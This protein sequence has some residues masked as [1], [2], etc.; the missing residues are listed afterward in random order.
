[1]PI[2]LSNLSAE[3]IAAAT[4]AVEAARRARQERERREVEE[5]RKHQ[6]EERARQ[7]A[8]MRREAE[9]RKEAVAWKAEAEWRDRM[10]REKAAREAAAAET[11]ATV[12][13]G[14]SGLKLTIP[15]PA[16]I[17]RTASGSSTQSKGK[18]KAAEEEP[19]TSQCV[20]FIPFSFLADFLWRSRFL[21]CDSCTIIGIPCSTE[22]RKNGMRR[23]LCDRCRQLKKACHWDLVGVTGPRD[24]NAPKRARKTVKKPVIDVDDLE[25]S[26][27]EAPSPSTDLTAS[28]FAVRN[29]ANALV[30]KSATIRATL[31][32][33]QDTLAGSLDRLTEFMVKEQAEAR[34]NRHAVRDLLQ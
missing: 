11:A 18:R 23:T 15:A 30:T 8:I 32:Q 2:D 17:A 25:D 26:G 29:A 34:E 5:R 19:S 27:D 20:A 7:E 4:A 24:P 12:T 22:L 1:M 6:E 31:V 14:L 3:D 33:F 10:A 28:V 13:T 9:Q 21:S 16:S